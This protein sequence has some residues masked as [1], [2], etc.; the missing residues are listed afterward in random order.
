MPRCR[1]RAGAEHEILMMLFV[2][3]IHLVSAG[4]LNR[5]KILFD[6]FDGVDGFGQTFHAKSQS[7]TDAADEAVPLLQLAARLT[8][9]ASSGTVTV[10]EIEQAS[11]S[12]RN[13]LL[14]GSG[15]SLEPLRLFL[16]PQLG[17]F[18]CTSIPFI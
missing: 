2:G 8:P 14:G 7:K 9:P 1:A 12:G 4:G 18:L 5:D 10:V 6:S 17:L 16:N 11:K 15:G 13:R 3:V